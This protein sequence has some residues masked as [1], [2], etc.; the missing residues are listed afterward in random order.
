MTASPT[1]YSFSMIV[2]EVQ[3]AGY[4]ARKER[5]ETRWRSCVRG[6]LDIQTSRGAISGTIPRFPEGNAMYLLLKSTSRH[7]DLPLPFGTIPQNNGT[8][9]HCC[10]VAAPVPSMHA[11]ARNALG[12]NRKKKKDQILQSLERETKSRE[13]QHKLYDLNTI[14][15]FGLLYVCLGTEARA[16]CSE[17]EAG[18][19]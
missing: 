14:Y 2:A 18:Q 1:T 15:V 9:M 19:C 6:D 10:H 16:V 12:E 4:G 13:V 7:A 11:Q 17:K 8:W 5:T 3:R